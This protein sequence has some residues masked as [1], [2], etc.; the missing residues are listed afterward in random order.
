MR[1]PCRGRCFSD[2]IRFIASGGPVSLAREKPGKERGRGAPLHPPVRRALKRRGQRL[3]D[4]QAGGIRAS[5]PLMILQAKLVCFSGRPSIRRSRTLP[6]EKARVRFA[7]ASDYLLQRP[8]IRIAV[9]HPRRAVCLLA[10]AHSVREGPTRG[11]ARTLV[12]RGSDMPQ[13]RHSLPRPCFAAPGGRWLRR[14]TE[15]GDG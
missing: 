15:A 3:D 1:G 9:P 7:P 10:A 6:Q 2:L 5:A 8:V 14:L 12:R 4:K 13:A 11:R